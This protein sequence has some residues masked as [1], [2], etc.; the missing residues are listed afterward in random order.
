M[1]RSWYLIREN[2]SKRI[3]VRHWNLGIFK[4][5]RQKKRNGNMLYFSLPLSFIFLL[6]GLFENFLKN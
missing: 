5:L 6:S 3:E 4:N 1:R 2:I